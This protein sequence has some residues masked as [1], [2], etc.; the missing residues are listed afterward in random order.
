MHK[1][2]WPSRQF[3]AGKPV[4]PTVSGTTFDTVTSSLHLHLQTIMCVLLLT[5]QHGKIPR[6]QGHQRS[7]RRELAFHGKTSRAVAAANIPGV[8]VLLTADGLSLA[9]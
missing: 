5:Y 3:S 8:S 9:L 1:L 2:H 4:G 6:V 7:G